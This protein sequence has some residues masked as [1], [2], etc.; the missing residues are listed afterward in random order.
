[1]KQEKIGA[2]VDVNDS[3]TP[4]L[5]WGTV[6]PG[7]YDGVGEGLSAEME[8]S[9]SAIKEWAGRVARI[10]VL[11]EDSC[12]PLALSA[13]VPR[14]KRKEKAKGKAKGTANGRGR[15]EGEKKAAAAWKR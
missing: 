13:L 2:L 7:V 10:A 6:C 14:R 9:G 15:C 12:L 1:M 11:P 5:R 8:V 4:R 3:F